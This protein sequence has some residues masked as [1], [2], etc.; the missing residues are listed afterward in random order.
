MKAVNYFCKKLVLDV[1]LGTAFCFV[2]HFLTI[3]P[4]PWFI[5]PTLVNLLQRDSNPQPEILRVES[6]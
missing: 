6:L 2:Y 1:L 3:F 4:K 5:N